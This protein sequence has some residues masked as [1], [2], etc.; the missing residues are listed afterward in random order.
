MSNIIPHSTKIDPEER[1]ALAMWLE[2]SGFQVSER[3][4]KWVFLSGCIEGVGDM[5]LTIPTRENDFGQGDQAVISAIELIAHRY[6][7]EFE[8]A[9]FRISGYDRDLYKTK[10]GDGAFIPIKSGVSYPRELKAIIANARAAEVISAKPFFSSNTIQNQKIEDYELGHTIRK[11]YIITTRSPRHGASTNVVQRDIWDDEDGMPTHIPP[12]TRRISERIVRSLSV[13]NETS[14]QDDKRPLY[15]SYALALNAGISK[16]LSTILNKSDEPVSFQTIW[17]PQLPPTDGLDANPIY[18]ISPS[19]SDDLSY[20]AEQL[21]ERHPEIVELHVIVFGMET[22]EPP[23]SEHA[24]R[25]VYARWVDRKPRP[26][27]IQLDVHTAAMYTKAQDAHN[28]WKPVR[29][30]G[31]LH[32]N[33]GRYLLTDI[34][35]FDY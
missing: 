31:T 5:E 18:T 9:R 35:E 27:K 4:R 14:S 25:K 10:V 33:M 1:H 8:D 7:E 16:S 26:V 21:R 19:I 2:A 34:Q 13:V 12:I 23:F 29:V 11:S 20:A 6:D 15:N 24:T 17:S 32:E 30:R 3:N 28:R 22:S